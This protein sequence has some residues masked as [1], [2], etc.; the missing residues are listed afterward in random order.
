MVSPLPILATSQLEGTFGIALIAVIDVAGVVALAVG[1]RSAS[2]AAIL[3]SLLGSVYFLQAG[4]P[5]VGPWAHLFGS[6]KAPIYLVAGLIGTRQ[7]KQ[8]A[9]RWAGVMLPA[10]AAA[11]MAW[12]FFSGRSLV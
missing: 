9:V 4:M 12:G 6:V 7:E 10:L 11:H 8:A 1:F 5:E 2:R 3:A